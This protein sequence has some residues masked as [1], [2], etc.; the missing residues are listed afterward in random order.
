[1]SEKI[2]RRRYDLDW[3]RVGAILILLGVVF[4]LQNLNITF[5]TRG[6]RLVG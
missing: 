3:L 5:L 2:S 6:G 4:L 1:M